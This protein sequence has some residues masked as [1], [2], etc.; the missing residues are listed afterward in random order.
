MIRYYTLY[1]LER[2][3][4][5]HDINVRL[6]KAFLLYGGI[7]WFRQR[8]IIIININFEE[9]FV[10]IYLNFSISDISGKEG[11]TKYKLS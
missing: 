3:L 1:Y 10:I 9:D 2:K 4:I 8:R 11:I 5:V 6:L 7:Y